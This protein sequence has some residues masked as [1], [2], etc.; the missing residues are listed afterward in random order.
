VTQRLSEYLTRETTDY[1]E[2]LEQLL[3]S[4]GAPDPESLLRLARG[5]R[6]SAEMAGMETIGSVAERLEDA[7]RSV[8]SNTIVW[9]EEI[10]Q[11]ASQTVGDLKILVRA[12]NRWGPGE[13]A[14]VR[15]AILRWD[16]AEMADGEVVPISSL[17]YDDE[18]PHVLDEVVPIGT[19]LFTGE[20]AL[21]EALRL[22]PELERLTAAGPGPELDLL[23]AELFDLIEAGRP[24][25]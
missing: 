25:A 13:E 10:R 17:F 18:G 22:R 15:A 1:L 14:R 20:A 16:E 21:R 19:L 4:S 23:L 12:L 8:L 9:S 2:Q 6:G 11:L 5:V 3:A 7:A 24:A